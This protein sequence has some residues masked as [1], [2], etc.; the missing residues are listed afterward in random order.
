LAP[1][2]YLRPIFVTVKVTLERALLLAPNLNAPSGRNRIATVLEKQ[3]LK[4]LEQRILD[5]FD[6]NG[7]TSV[8]VEYCNQR[9]Q[10]GAPP[11]VGTSWQQRCSTLVIS[12]LTQMRAL[13]C[14]NSSDSFF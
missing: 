14:L 8:G 10:R 13:A 3:S 1:E 9:L 7:A 6:E 2:G 4:T 12:Y 5:G 11:Q